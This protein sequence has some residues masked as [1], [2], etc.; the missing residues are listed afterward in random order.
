M[1]EWRDI[2]KSYRALKEEEKPSVLATLVHMEGTSFRMPGAKMLIDSQGITTSSLGTCLEKDLV[3]HSK[4]VLKTGQP[5]KVVYDLT[6][7]DEIVFGLGL[8]CQG[9]LQIL[10]ERLPGKKE[11]DPLLFLEESLSLGKDGIM[12]TVIDPGEKTGVSLGDRWMV[13]GRVHRGSKTLSPFLKDL[14]EKGEDLTLAKRWKWETLPAG[15]GEITVL[16]ESLQGVSLTILGAHPIALPLSEMASILGWQVRVVDHRPFY[17]QKERFPQA[18]EVIHCPWQ[19]LKAPFT[20]SKRSVLV[21]L[22]HNYLTDRDLLKEL[23]PS[24]LQYIGML[25]S[26]KRR[27]RIFGDLLK[28]GLDEKFLPKLHCPLGL[29]TGGDSPQEIAL[30]CISEIQSVLYQKEVVP[31]KDKA[32]SIHPRIC[33]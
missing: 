31:L 1:K 12:A 33:L 14:E 2:C 5:K 10:L 13:K 32:N 29:D 4:E 23:L 11:E 27:D 17:A 20:F 22:T 21:I 6:S 26:R 25:S 28:E 16:I 24:P 3:E 30:S 9:K 15:E 8:G 18:D 7:P 19:N